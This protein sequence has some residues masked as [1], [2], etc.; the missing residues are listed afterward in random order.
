M[1]YLH[2]TKTQTFLTDVSNILFDNNQ[3]FNEGDYI[4]QQNTLWELNAEFKRLGK[5]YSDDIC[6]DYNKSKDIL[7][8]LIDT[9]F[10]YKESFTEEQSKLFQENLIK[11]YDVYMITDLD[12]EQTHLR[13]LGLPDDVPTSFR[14]PLVLKYCIEEVKRAACGNAIGAIGTRI[15]VGISNISKAEM[16]SD[17]IPLLQSEGFDVRCV[18]HDLYINIDEFKIFWQKCNKQNSRLTE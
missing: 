13:G 2:D 5:K 12:Y 8:K 18:I 10:K 9:I 11:L 7:S 15:P 1:F 4:L 3:L 14:A 16:L 6:K 17:I